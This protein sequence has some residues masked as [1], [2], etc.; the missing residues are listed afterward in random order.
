MKPSPAPEEWMVPVNW[1]DENDGLQPFDTAKDPVSL[2]GIDPGGMT[3]WS[4]LTTTI[5]KIRDTDLTLE[6]TVDLWHHGEIPTEGPWGEQRAVDLLIEMG[7]NA[8]GY[9]TWVIEDFRVRRL[10]KTREFLSPPRLIGALTQIIWQDGLGLNMQT[11]RDKTSVT[12]ERLKS[13]GFYQRGMGHARDADRHSLY[14]LRRLR[15]QPALLR[16]AF[17]L[18]QL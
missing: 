15:D 10:D 16:A 7:H 17:P 18:L 13:W 12:D 9:P 1:S 6:Q 14:L 5:D 2:I 8:P 11:P 4:I 3:G